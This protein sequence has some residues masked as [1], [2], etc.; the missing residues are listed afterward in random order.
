MKLLNYIKI[1]LLLLAALISV[2]FYT[3]AIGPD[4]LLFFAY[5]LAGV[6]V[7]SVGGFYLYGLLEHPKQVK[8][9]LLVLAGVVVLTFLCYI[10]S[11]PTAVGL[12]PELERITSASAIRWSE[13]SIYAMYFLAFCAIASIIYGSVRNTLK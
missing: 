13:T 8:F 10:M 12:D 2:L 1:A 7:V 3:N 5:F 4:I 11:S 9:V 6:T